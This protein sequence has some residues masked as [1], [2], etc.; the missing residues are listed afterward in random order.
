MVGVRGW[1]EGSAINS[2]HTG[3]IDRLEPSGKGKDG[4]EGSKFWLRVS[5]SAQAMALPEVSQVDSEESIQIFR[6]R[7]SD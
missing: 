5:R 3:I 7:G 4:C 2:T 1:E 6:W